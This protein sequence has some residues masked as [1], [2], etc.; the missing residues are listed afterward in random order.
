MCSRLL[1]LT[2]AECSLAYFSTNI[3]SEV[4][5]SEAVDRRQR[6]SDL[7]TESEYHSGNYANVHVG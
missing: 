7:Q 2:S 3:S 5:C 1:Q 4:D 6:N